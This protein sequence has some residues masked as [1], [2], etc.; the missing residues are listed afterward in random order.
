MTRSRKLSITAILS[1]AILAACGGGGGGQIGDA[2]AQFGQSFA[3]AFRSVD[4][5][6]P[7][8]P[9]PVTY[10]Q[11]ADANEELRLTQEP[12]DF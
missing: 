6:E 2:A 8:E 4:T 3:A 1:L 12:V 10:L 11:V 9:G 7:V 5:A